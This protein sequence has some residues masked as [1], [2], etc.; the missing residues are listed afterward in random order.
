MHIVCPD[1]N[2]TNNVPDEKTADNPKCGKC[3]SP[4]F[5]GSV[6]EL[7]Q[8]SFMT[9]TTKN[10]IPTVVDFWAPWCGPC[11]SFA[12][13]FAEIASEE[14][15]NFRFAK[16]NT[17]EHQAISQQFGIR[18]IPTLMVF[19]EGKIV[20]QISGALPKNEFKRWINQYA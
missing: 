10:H 17:E 11:V 14:E 20:G 5:A 7:D 8:N 1:C 19:K 13:T 6:V 15:P 4:L 18:S 2:T 3:K 12:P 9:H 16:L